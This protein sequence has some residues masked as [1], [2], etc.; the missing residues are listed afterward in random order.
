MGYE[1]GMGFGIVGRIK[2]TVEVR[3][4]TVKTTIKNTKDTAKGTKPFQPGTIISDHINGMRQ[5]NQELAPGIK[6]L[7]S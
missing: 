5:S 2:K 3:A 7:T 4:N 1:E 6:E